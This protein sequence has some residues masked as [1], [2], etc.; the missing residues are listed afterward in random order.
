MSKETYKRLKEMA[1]QNGVDAVFQAIAG[2]ADLDGKA[3]GL[4]LAAKSA[5]A[6]DP[7]ASLSNDDLDALA[8]DIVALKEKRAQGAQ[9]DVL[10]EVVGVD[11]DA[12]TEAMTKAFR[13]VIAEQTDALTALLTDRTTEQVA[14]ARKANELQTQIKEL[15]TQLDELH[16]GPKATKEVRQNGYRPSRQNPSATAARTAQKGG[17]Y[18]ALQD[19]VAF[20]NG[21]EL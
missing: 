9:G 1:A 14:A 5:D 7:L 20:L 10:E 13:G 18:S 8:A 21:E 16:A 15:Q 12:M 17:D 2:V 4:G 19:A 3:K 6:A 11:M